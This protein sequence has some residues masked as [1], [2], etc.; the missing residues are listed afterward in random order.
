MV[1]III[2]NSRLVSLLKSYILGKIKGWCHGKQLKGISYWDGLHNVACTRFISGNLLRIVLKSIE[3]NWKDF[4][5]MK[6]D[7]FTAELLSFEDLMSRCGFF[8]S[9][10][11]AF[12]LVLTA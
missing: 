10:N 9:G 6:K 8:E 3:K 5:I 4:V 12:E 1:Y 7:T 11:V 2:F